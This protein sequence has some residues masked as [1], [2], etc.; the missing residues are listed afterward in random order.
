MNAA[1]RGAAALLL[2]ALPAC[3]PSTSLERV[4][5]P[6]GSSL[7]AAADSLKAH[8][9]IWSTTY[10]RMRARWV[11]ADR[12]V[13]AGVYQL[14]RHA[15]IPV[16][17]HALAIGDA[18]H[19]RITLPQGGT[20]IDLA[21]AAGRL[22]ISTDSILAAAHDSSLL[23]RLGID[24]PSAEGWLLPETFEFGQFD[25][26]RTVITRFATARLSSWDAN[27][28]VQAKAQGLDRRELLTLASLVEAEAA[29]PA[30]RALIAAV[31][32]NR[33]KRGMPLQADPSIEYSYLITSGARKGRLS[34]VDYRLDSPWNTYLHPGLPPG[35]IDNP[36]RDAIEAVLAAPRVPY[37]YFVAGGDGR[38]HFATTYPEHLR[39]IRR[40]LAPPMAPVSR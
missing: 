30:D 7:R 23:H 6:P 25:S 31:Y 20:I 12:S 27:W 19:F 4:P 35:P 9:V 32:R 39:N 40:Y 28:D 1:H 3:G 13:K 18:M 36:S 26:A 37:L 22:G 14:P 33:L 10:F 5:I 2:L 8:G 38:S 24:G 16:I 15:P 17:L 34:D 29:N 21:H 11:H